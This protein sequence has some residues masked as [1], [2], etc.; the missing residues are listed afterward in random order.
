MVPALHGRLCRLK[1]SNSHHATGYDLPS[2]S[3]QFLDRLVC[4]LA[5]LITFPCEKDFRLSGHSQ[6]LLRLYQT[7][8]LSSPANTA[9]LNRPRSRQALANHAQFEY[10]ERLRE[11]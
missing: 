10:R 1:T 11:N 9:I 2:H 5:T 6:S 3:K 7:K 4:R 8:S